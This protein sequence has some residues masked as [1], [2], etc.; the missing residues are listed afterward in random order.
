MVRKVTNCGWDTFRDEN[1]NDAK[2]Q[3]E[4]DGTE[5][6]WMYAIYELGK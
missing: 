2:Y 1:G 3:N 4:E 6:P 5:I